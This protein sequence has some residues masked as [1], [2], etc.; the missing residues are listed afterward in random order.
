MEV[1]MWSTIFFTSCCF[2]A[3]LLG[4]KHGRSYNNHK[5]KRSVEIFSHYI[6][7]DVLNTRG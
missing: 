6:S 7:D 3:R 1:A 2:L 5:N 4:A